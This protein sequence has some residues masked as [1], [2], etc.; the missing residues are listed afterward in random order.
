MAAWIVLIV[1]A[2]GWDG[3][4]FVAQQHDLP[5]L[6]RLVGAVTAWSWGRALLVVAWAAWGAWS[7]LGFRRPPS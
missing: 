7:A 4:S 5:T 3:A 2:I 6:S 1:V